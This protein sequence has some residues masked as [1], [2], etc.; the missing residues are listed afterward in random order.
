MCPERLLPK[1]CHTLAKV[2]SLIRLQTAF[3]SDRLARGAARLPKLAGECLRL[4]NEQKR[5]AF[6][7]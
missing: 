1:F 3:L 4:F 7:I 5:V 6:G 2:V